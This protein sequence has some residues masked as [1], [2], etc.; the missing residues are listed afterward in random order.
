MGVL[1]TK[2]ISIVVCDQQLPDG[3]WKDILDHSVDYREHLTLIVSSRLAD[4]CLW[5]EVLTLGAYDI[6]SKPFDEHEV[7]RVITGAWIREASAIRTSA[8]SQ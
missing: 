8:A 2:R 6:L 4:D 1:R 7:R 3:I 5:A